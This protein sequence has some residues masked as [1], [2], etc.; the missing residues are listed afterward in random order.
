V[1]CFVDIARVLG[2]TTVAEF[3]DDP[4]ILERLG[5]LGV[6]YAQ[7]FLVH[8]PEALCDALRCDQAER[9]SA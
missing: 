7:G 9:A 3:V 8:R 1:R 5:Q 4:A 6:D 2:V